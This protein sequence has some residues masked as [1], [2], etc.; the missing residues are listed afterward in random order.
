MSVAAWVLWFTAQALA[1]V[2][3][4]VIAMLGVTGRLTRQPSGTTTRPARRHTHHLSF[5][6][7]RHPLTH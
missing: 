3:I 7:L 6:H 2:A 1:F 5:R 4:L